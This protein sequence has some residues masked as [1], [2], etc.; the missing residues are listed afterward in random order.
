[1]G[2]GSIKAFEAAGTWATKAIGL[3]TMSE[4]GALV[5]LLPQQFSWLPH[6]INL[7]RTTFGV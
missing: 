1:M 7:I 2:S 6:A 5:G 4:V 3:L